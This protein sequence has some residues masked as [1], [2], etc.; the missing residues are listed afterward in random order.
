M[1]AYKAE[2]RVKT[3]PSFPYAERR[4][5][6]A[7]AR[8]CGLAKNRGRLS[9]LFGFADPLIAERYAAA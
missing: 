9:L 8:Y 5:G 2:M 7:K 4:F 1:A 6:Q 3:A